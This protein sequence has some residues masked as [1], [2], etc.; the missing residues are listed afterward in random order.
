MQLKNETPTP[1]PPPPPTPLAAKKKKKRNDLNLTLLLSLSHQ[2][3]LGEHSMKHHL[4]VCVFTTGTCQKTLYHL[5]NI[6]DSVGHFSCR[7]IEDTFPSLL[8]VFHREKRE[9]IMIRKNIKY[10]KKERKR[11]GEKNNNFSSHNSTF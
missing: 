6:R 9:K 3:L 8:Y 5:V 7:C 1:N 4:L 10:L 11:K 2:R